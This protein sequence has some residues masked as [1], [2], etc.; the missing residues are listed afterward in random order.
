MRRPEVALKAFIVNSVEYAAEHENKI[1]ISHPGVSKY[2]H[3][4]W[5][6]ENTSSKASTSLVV[7]TLIVLANCL[8]LPLTPLLPSSWEHELEVRLRVRITEGKSPLGLIWVLPC[9]RFALWMLSTVTLGVFL[10]MLP[11]IPENSGDG[12]SLIELWPDL[13]MAVWIGGLVELEATQIMGD[14]LKY[15]EL[16]EYLSD[17]F[18]ILDL[19]TILVMSTMTA[20]RAVH[21]LNSDVMG[22]Q[23]EQS[24]SWMYIGMMSQAIGALVVWLRLLQVL[25][26][27][28]A[29]GP[30]LLMT[31]RMLDDLWKFLMLAAIILIAFGCAFYVILS[32]SGPYPPGEDP[33]IFS[34]LG[35]LTEAA[36]NGEPVQL[37]GIHSHHHKATFL[38]MCLFGII[39]VLLL[40]NL[41]IA[42]FAKTFDMVYEN[43]D[44][45]FNV[46]F[47]RVVVKGHAKSLL[48][49]PLNF[50]RRFFLLVYKLVRRVKLASHPRGWIL[51]DAQGNEADEEEIKNHE[52]A[53]K[54]QN[55]IE[56]A[57]S[58]NV[59]PEGVADYVRNHRHDIAEESQWRVGLNKQIDGVLFGMSRQMLEIKSAVETVQS[60][61]PAFGLPAPALPP[62]PTIVG[63]GNT[64]E[65]VASIDRRMISLE[66]EMRG[67]LKSVEEKEKINAQRLKEA[68]S[69]MQL[70]AASVASGAPAAARASGSRSSGLRPSW[71]MGGSRRQLAVPISASS[72]GTAAEVLPTQQGGAAD[73]LQQEQTVLW[74]GPDG[75]RH[76]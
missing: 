58:A 38:F 30:L 20:S 17:P 7:R 12:H 67:M 54:T 4:L 62:G 10:T 40:L 49:P 35:L 69:A 15:G 66:A 14:L 70:M 57:V 37:L 1:V 6:P 18:N 74:Q 76:V 52:V 56:R 5:W 25:F 9:G 16:R 51:H 13:L 19:T 61:R 50:V 68:V 48:P 71:S 60:E 21:Y 27:F 33:H 65:A 2:L 11:E 3:D 46:V 8:V 73:V 26:V 72:T 64:A 29:T 43:L 31:L 42:R 41:L 59:F 32:K 47:A 55:F 45:N 53:S 75:H 22:M 28:H 36:L 23:E 44:A 39:V 34:V 24:T 63:N